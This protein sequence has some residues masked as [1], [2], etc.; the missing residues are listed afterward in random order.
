MQSVRLSGAE[1]STDLEIDHGQIYCKAHPA[2]VPDTLFII[3]TM[4]FILIKMLPLPA[5]IR[6]MGRDVNLILAKRDQMGYNK[7]LCLYSISCSSRA[8]L[9]HWD[10]G[11][12]EQMYE[13]LNVWDVLLTKTTLHHYGESVFDITSHSIGAWLWYI[14]G[15]EK[16]QMAG[17][18][19][20]NMSSLC[21]FLFPV[22]CMLLLC[23]TCSV[24]SWAGS[25]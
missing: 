17:S 2:D 3:M 1:K 15:T 25:R 4:C 14:C 12:G 18:R 6:E 23:N 21:L 24:I 5:V 20:V 10:W 9:Q 11:V 16:E 13:A 7:P 8:S 22:M 19:C